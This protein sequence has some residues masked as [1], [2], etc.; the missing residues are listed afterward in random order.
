MTKNI[1]SKIPISSVYDKAAD[2]QWNLEFAAFE[3][4]Q[5]AVF[6]H[7]YAWIAD[8]TQLQNDSKKANG[9]MIGLVSG[10]KESQQTKK[11]ELGAT[12]A[13]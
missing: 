1:Q 10:S 3:T 6:S 5:C 8:S 7:W 2:F 11:I 12:N 4:L 13:G 9:L